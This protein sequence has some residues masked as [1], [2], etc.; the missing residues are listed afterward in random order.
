MKDTKRVLILGFALFAMFF[1]AGNVLLPSA[2]GLRVGEHLLLATIGFVITGVGLPLV[3]LLV[4]FKNKGNY[5]TLFDPM[6][7]MFSKIFLLLAFLS[8][9]PIIA[10]PRTAATTFEMGIYPIFPSV[11]ATIVTGIF[12]VLCILFCINKAKVLDEIGKILTPLLLITLIILI[13]LG[14]FN[15]D[16]VVNPVTVKNVFTFSFLEGYNTL[17]AIAAIIFGQLIY[18]AV[19]NEKNAMK[20]SIKASFIA[21]IGLMGVYAG[22]MYLGNTV[23][24]PNAIQ[25]DRT[26][27]T[28][29]ITEV[30]LGNYGKIILGIITSLA[31]LT[32]AIG[33]IAS[34]SEFFEELLNEKIDYKIIVIVISTISFIISQ[35]KVDIIIK[36]AGPILNV[37]YP[38]LIVLI[39]LTI[40]KGR[41][42]T[43]RVIF[44]TT[45]TTLTIAII[46]QIMANT[47]PLSQIGMAWLVPTVIVLMIS[48]LV[49]EFKYG[50]K[51]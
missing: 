14:I 40:F 50:Y 24:I 6:G 10:I 4:V 2:I 7:K 34:V 29:K 44:Y 32:T 22:L 16:T 5:L 45:Y 30:L 20:L 12:F 46:D 37:F 38:V 17:D 49:K 39:G 21:L 1:G 9:G 33:L 28:I 42:I 25:Y 13:V 18:K 3:G 8:I 51:S 15:K 19:K 23:N 36:L 48:I 35:L 26:E 43:D 47:L 41:L 27:Y 11:N 31:C